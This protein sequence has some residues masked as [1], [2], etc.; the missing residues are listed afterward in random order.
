MKRF[1]SI[2]LI[3]AGVFGLF[4]DILNVRDAFACKSYWEKKSD[5]SKADLNMLAAGLKKMKKDKKTYL[6]GVKTVAKSRKTLARSEA[7]Y[8]AA[9][10]KLR[11]AK[12][13]LNTG[14]KDYKRLVSFIKSIS[15]LRT[16]YTK[17]WK[18]GYDTI[19]SGWSSI[20]ERLAKDAPDTELGGIY[21]VDALA[22]CADYIRDDTAKASFVNAVKAIDYY[23]PAGKSKKQIRG[24]QEYKDFAANCTTAASA[25]DDL[26][27]EMKKIKSA[28]TKIASF[29]TDEELEEA[30]KNNPEL[31]N[32]TIG[33][34][35]LD[36]GVVDPKGVVDDAIEGDMMALEEVKMCATE[37]VIKDEVKSS[38]KNF[39][40]LKAYVTEDMKKRAVT[41]NANVDKLVKVQDQLAQGV[42]DIADTVLRNKT[43]KKGIVKALGKDAVPFLEKYR[44]MPNPLSSSKASLYEFAYQ[45]E[46]NPG[47]IKLLAKAQTYMNKERTNA[48]KAYK[49]ATTKYKKSLTSYKKTP[50]KL[51]TA[52]KKLAAAEA[53]LTKYEKG[54]KQSETALQ[55]LMATEG[56]GG[57][58]S[59]ADRVGDAGFDDKNG[60]LDP[61]KGLEAVSAGEDYLNE[62][63]AMVTKELT[64]RFLSTAVGVIAAGLALLAGLLSLLRSNRGGAVIACFSAITGA[65]AAVYG[66]EAGTVFSEI[67]GSNVGALPWIAAAVI[68][69]VSLAFAAMHFAAKIEEK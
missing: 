18:T 14:K 25:V 66:N 4:T 27:I 11:K 48:L 60:R 53:K 65:A 24:A 34:V 45:M 33:L 47:I 68:A 22:S 28:Q 12:K 64:N 9:T 1:L 42:A 20:T 57:V 8:Y 31:Y 23:V 62:V 10:G 41:I 7:T 50:A 30:L 49:T 40:W 51:K 32:A 38:I 2:L 44:K 69:G 63:G 67:A 37:P 54:E 58:K 29:K 59:I 26:T 13:Q 61:G 46:T 16:T 52:R 3:A 35:S 36:T 55:D 43:Y 19:H 56:E 39:M 15:K 5:K 17:T 21:V 6:K